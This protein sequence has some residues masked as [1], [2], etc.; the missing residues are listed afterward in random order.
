MWPL[1]QVTMSAFTCCATDPAASTAS[2]PLPNHRR[3]LLCRHDVLCFVDRPI[4]A[5][6]LCICPISR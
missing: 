2:H 3:P 5:V 6:H 4:S 1:H